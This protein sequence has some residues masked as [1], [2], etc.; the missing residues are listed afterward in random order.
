M[1]K[2]NLSCSIGIFTIACITIGTLYHVFNFG[3]NSPWF[4]WMNSGSNITD[5]NYIENY[6]ETIDTVIIDLKMADISVVKRQS[7]WNKLYL[8]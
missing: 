4:N 3:H 1:K 7:S 8:Q 6:D 2:R 5:S